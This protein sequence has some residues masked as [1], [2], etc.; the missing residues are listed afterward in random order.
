MEFGRRAREHFVTLIE[1]GVHQ[2]RVNPGPISL[3][4]CKVI[5][6]L[7]IFWEYVLGSQ[8]RRKNIVRVVF[9]AKITIKASMLTLCENV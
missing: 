3:N 6:V 9:Q 4:K 1:I 8:I 5:I 2:I 7:F